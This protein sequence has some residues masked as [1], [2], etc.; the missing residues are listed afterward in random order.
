MGQV[1]VALLLAVMFALWAEALAPYRSS[2]DTWIYRIGHV[3]VILSIF[4]AFLAFYTDNTTESG[5]GNGNGSSDMYGS[6]LVAGNVFWV[7]A[8]VVEGVTTAFSDMVMEDHV[9]RAVSSAVVGFRDDNFGGGVTTGSAVSRIEKVDE[10]YDGEV[11][12]VAERPRFRVSK[13]F[14]MPRS[15]HVSPYDSKERMGGVL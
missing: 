13:T 6:A 10:D 2:W 1:A 12:R 5:N 11:Y 3:V 9:P 8:V 14:P 7:V 4:V 15:G